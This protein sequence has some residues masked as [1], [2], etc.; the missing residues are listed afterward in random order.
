[1]SNTERS[2]G[3]LCGAVRYVARGEPVRAPICHCQTCQKNTGSPFLAALVF[4]GGRIEIR[5]ELKSFKAPD[6]DRRFCPE[7]G[8]LV[9]LVRPGR[10]ERILML[11]S[12]DEPPSFVPDY[13]IFITR[14]HPWLPKITG[15]R[16]YAEYTDGGPLAE[17]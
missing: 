1:M 17:A 4:A 6:V 14:R 9:C 16:R 8:S 15:T 2:G 12:F 5:G 7:C 13:E 11:G 3:C 10:E